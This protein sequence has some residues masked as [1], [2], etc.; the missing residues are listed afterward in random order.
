MRGH[1]NRVEHQTLHL[2]F[3]S[4]FLPASFLA[5]SA[6]CR[7]AP[8]YTTICSTMRKF[9]LKA[10]MVPPSTSGS[11]T[12]CRMVKTRASEPSVLSAYVG[13]ASMPVWPC[14][15]FW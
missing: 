10:E 9:W 1:D 12:S 8:R 5:A 13:I 4:S 6:R 3:F 11:L 15:T 14:R 7:L 2:D